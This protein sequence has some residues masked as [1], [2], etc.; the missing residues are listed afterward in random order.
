MGR[1]RPPYF[2]L[3]QQG[4]RAAP[5]ERL[6]RLAPARGID[7]DRR[8]QLAQLRRRAGIEAAV[9]ALGEPRDLAEGFL[10]AGVCA[11]LEQEHRHAQQRQLARPAAQ[12]VDLLLHAVADVDQRV[13]ATLGPA[14]TRAWLSTLPICV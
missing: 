6:Q 10:R 13:H 9:G 12:I 8:Q 1:A 14:S 4:A 11:L 7:R 2:E 5:G 3:L